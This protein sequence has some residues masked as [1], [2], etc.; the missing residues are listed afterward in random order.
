[1]HARAGLGRAWAHD[2]L[3]CETRALTHRLVAHSPSCGTACGPLRLWPA[4]CAQNEPGGSG[5]GG[6]IRPCT[7]A[8]RRWPSEKQQPAR[9][10]VYTCLAQTQTLAA[11]ISN[12]PRKCCAWGVVQSVLSFKERGVC[13][14]HQRRTDTRL[15][16]ACTSGHDG[17]RKSRR[18]L[19]PACKLHGNKEPTLPHA[20]ASTLRDVTR[21]LMQTAN[22]RPRMPS[23]RPC[24][25]TA[26]HPGSHGTVLA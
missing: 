9:A 17:Q 26:A 11:H 14:Q 1:M 7:A 20:A 10:H 2:E 12:P 3:K 19:P 4:P 6:P 13:R 18:G 15:R 8:C 23:R 22:V 16:K 24:R 25:Q 21:M 5:R